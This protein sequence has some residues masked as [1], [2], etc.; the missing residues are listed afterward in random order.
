M[1]III[2]GTNAPTLGTV[3]IGNGTEL[4]FTAVG[5]VGQVLTSNGS[6]MPTWVNAPTGA[7]DFILQMTGT[8]VAP[9]QG[10]DGLGII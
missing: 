1:A 3:G 5:T 9:T 8:N 4:A 2:N 6:S 7:Q 10:T